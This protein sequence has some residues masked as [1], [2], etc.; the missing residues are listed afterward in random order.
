MRIV[1]LGGYGVFGGRLA[2]LLMDMPELEIV[3]AGRSLAKAEAFCAGLRGAAQVAPRALDRADISRDLIGL[4]VDVLVD[5]S[6][7]FQGYGEDPYAVVRACIEAGVAYLDLADAADFVFG[8]DQFDAQ[9]RAAG[10]PVLAGVSSFPVL[11]AAVVRRLGRDM[12][13]THVTGGIAPSP[14]AGVGMNVMRAVLSYAG[15]PVTVWRGGRADVLPGL[16]SVRRYTVSVPGHVPLD[17]ILFSLVDVPDLRVLP[18]EHPGMQEVW[19]GAG[20]VPEVLHRVLIGLA[21]VRAKLR[22]PTLR[23]LAPLCY[24]VLNALKFGEHRGGMFVEVRGQRDGAEVVRSWHMLAEGD[25]GP[26]I[27]SMAVEALVRKMVAGEALEPGARSAVAAL[28]L[29]DYEALF[30]GR[31]IYSGERGAERGVYR[32]ILGAAYEGLPLS[33]Q[34]LHDLDGHAVWA[35]RAEVRRGRGVL[36]SLVARVFGFPP[37]AADVPVRVE[38]T[39]RDGVERWQ[40][41]FDGVRFFSDQSVG[42]GR[43]A[44]LLSERFGPVVVAMALELRAGAMYLVPRRWSVLGVPMPRWM[45]PAGTSHERDAGGAFCFDVEM[46]LPIIG[47]IVAYRGTLAPVGG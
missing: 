38:F 24:R 35:G 23:G 13:V 30:E 3:I 11:T 47:R 6:G 18:P 44:G 45:L 1:I 43:N 22:L 19:M 25:D 7:P 27:P 14:Y 33:V 42:T 37:E 31:A 8:V 17:N 40:R 39:V 5:A 10:V 15:S 28:E 41:D 16:A 36:A 29:A 2:E 46:R 4:S 20:P 12:E 9:A 34:R 21:W 26:Y 32:E